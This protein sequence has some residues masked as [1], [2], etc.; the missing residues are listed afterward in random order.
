MRGRAEPSNA[1]DRGA[2]KKGSGIRSTSRLHST[3]AGSPRSFIATG[4]GTLPRDFG[5]SSRAFAGSRM[6]SFAHHEKKR[7]VCGNAAASAKKA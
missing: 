2:L 6:R 1:A 5:K 7:Y 3:Q 4:L